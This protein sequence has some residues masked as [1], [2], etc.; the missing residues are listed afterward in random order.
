MNEKIKMVITK[1]IPIAVG[2]CAGSVIEKLVGIHI[3][4]QASIAG[5]ITQ[6]IGIWGVGAVVSAAVME[7]VEKEIVDALDITQPVFDL[8]EKNENRDLSNAMDFNAN[9][10]RM[11]RIGDVVA[12]TPTPLVE[13]KEEADG[14]STE[15]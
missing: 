4:E 1:G 2:I 13:M 5:K 6:K 9:A 8:F 7:Q 3:P 12:G 14:G 10:W 11:S 15:A